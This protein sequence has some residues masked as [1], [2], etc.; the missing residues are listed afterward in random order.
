[1]WGGEQCKFKR[2]VLKLLGSFLNFHMIHN[3]SCIILL[4]NN[5]FENKLK[6]F[7]EMCVVKNMNDGQTCEMNHSKK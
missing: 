7:M 2:E 1:M 6:E 4:K 3:S 5:I